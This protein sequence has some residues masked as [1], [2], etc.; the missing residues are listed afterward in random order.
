MTTFFKQIRI[1]RKVKPLYYAFY[2]GSTTQLSIQFACNRND[3][4]IYNN[5]SRFLKKYMR[6]YDFID[7]EVEGTDRFEKSDVALYYKRF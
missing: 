1:I 6:L 4:T 5:H 2:D 7:N 3:A